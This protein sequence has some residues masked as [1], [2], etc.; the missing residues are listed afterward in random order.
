[1]G[2]TLS[3]M[4]KLYVDNNETYHNTLLSAHLTFACAILD[5]NV[6]RR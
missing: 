5:S 2:S 4:I 1:M 3:P 6:P